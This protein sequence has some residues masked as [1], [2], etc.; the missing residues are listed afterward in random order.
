MSN[1][2]NHINKHTDILVM[3]IQ[4]DNIKPLQFF[5]H[6]SIVCERASF[7]LNSI[8][9]YEEVDGDGDDNIITLLSVSSSLSLSSRSLS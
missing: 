8:K 5:K 1:F 7:S 3:N 9:D 6:S 4:Y 2:D